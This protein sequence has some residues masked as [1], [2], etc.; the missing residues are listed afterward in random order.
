MTC[1]RGI[2]LA[3]GEGFLS[4]PQ[5][6]PQEAFEQKFECFFLFSTLI[7]LENEHHQQI[8]H[9]SSLTETFPGEYGENQ[10][11]WLGWDFLAL[12]MDEPEWPPKIKEISKGILMRYIKKFNWFW[13][14]R[15]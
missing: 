10:G 5:E 7:S 14:R 8:T 15:K 2:N 1:Y 12:R 9:V 3:L 4:I 6:W 11:K 13:N